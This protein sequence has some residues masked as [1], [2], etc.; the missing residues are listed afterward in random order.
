[1]NRLY[2]RGVPHAFSRASYAVLLLECITNNTSS[3]PWL[4]YVIIRWGFSVV[5]EV[6]NCPIGWPFV[7]N[8]LCIKVVFRSG[9]VAQSRWALQQTFHGR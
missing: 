4:C 2:V 1:M 9:A 6:E 3:S 7:G 8:I 5:P